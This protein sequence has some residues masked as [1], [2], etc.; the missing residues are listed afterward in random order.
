M[1]RLGWLDSTVGIDRNITTGFDAVQL[2]RSHAAV[3]VHTSTHPAAAAAGPLTV[4]LSGGRSITLDKSVGGM[5]ATLVRSIEAW[6]C[7]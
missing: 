7:L 6:L 2:S 3:S 4:M 1:A 5:A